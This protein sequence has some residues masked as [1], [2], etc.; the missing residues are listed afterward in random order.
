[1]KA[2]FKTLA[3][4]AALLLFGAAPFIGCSGAGDEGEVMTPE[5]EQ[6]MEEESEA[7]EADEAE[8]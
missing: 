7:D 8:E 2:L 4:S 5:E 1:M 6:Q 3:V